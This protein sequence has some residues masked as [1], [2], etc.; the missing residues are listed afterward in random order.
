ME[1]IA[2]KLS[3]YILRKNV[4]TQEMY[5]IYRYGFQVGIEVTLCTIVCLLIALLLGMF[6]EFIIFFAVFSAVRSYGGGL[7]MAHYRTCFVCS[8]MIEVVA[9]LVAKYV[10]FTPFVSMFLI[11]VLSMMIGKIGIVPNHNRVTDEEDLVYFTKCLK[12]SLLI[13]ILIG[14]IMIATKW[15]QYLSL[16]AVA[17]A[18][19]ASSMVLGKIQ[20]E[21]I[22]KA[23]SLYSSVK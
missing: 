2:T 1:K 19:N 22:E 12:R 18:I 17:L 4:I 8:C 7:H 10:V 6:L 11:L 16:L 23:N 3:D 21:R 9:L 5:E 15:N 14:S 20:Y 13:I